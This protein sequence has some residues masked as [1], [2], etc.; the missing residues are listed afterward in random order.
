LRTPRAAATSKP[1][2]LVNAAKFTA[3]ATR[4]PGSARQLN[5][6]RNYLISNG[7][8]SSGCSRAAACDQRPPFKPCAASS[9]RKYLKLFDNTEQKNAIR[10][11][12]IRV[13]SAND[14][15]ATAGRRHF[16][17]LRATC[18]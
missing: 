18:H 5:D 14:L 12:P 6:H 1:K 17:T 8:F 10:G 15:A 11:C 4:I 2:A 16:A 13:I 7:Y 3:I 9:N